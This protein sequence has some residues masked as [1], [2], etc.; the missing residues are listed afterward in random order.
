MATKKKP[1]QLR[2][3]YNAAKTSYQAA[4]KALA[5]VTKRKSPPVR[6]P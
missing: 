4:G 5:K 2:A 6:R 3:E 1:S